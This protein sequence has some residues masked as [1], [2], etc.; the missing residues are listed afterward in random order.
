MAFDGT[1][2]ELMQSVMER[3][4]QE[5]ENKGGKENGEILRYL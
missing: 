2:M 4:K 5:D 3:K 1:R